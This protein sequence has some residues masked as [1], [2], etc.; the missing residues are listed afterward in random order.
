MRL[1]HVEI[2]LDEDDMARI[3]LA[4]PHLRTL[5]LPDQPF[6]SPCPVTFKGLASLVRNC[7]V[8][9]WLS[10]PSIGAAQ[11]LFNNFDVYNT[12]RCSEN[13]MLVTLNVREPSINNSALVAALLS[14]PTGYLYRGIPRRL[15]SGDVFNQDISSGC[16][17]STQLMIP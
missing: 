7:Q 12:L 3:A 14:K 13:L 17:S 4:R 10:L 9:T 2:A 8:L 11:M 1:E 5:H 6:E 16:Y 15:A